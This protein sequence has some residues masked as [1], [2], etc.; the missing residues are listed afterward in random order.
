MIPSAKVTITTAAGLTLNNPTPYPYYRRLYRTNGKNTDAQCG[1][2]YGGTIYFCA[3][4][5]KQPALYL[6]VRLCGG[7]RRAGDV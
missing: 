1:Q 5:L 4:H 2:Y 3:Q 7:L 6:P